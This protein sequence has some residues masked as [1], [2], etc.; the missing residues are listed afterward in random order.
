MG[1]VVRQHSKLAKFAF[2][3]KYFVSA[4]LKLGSEFINYQCKETQDP[5]WVRTDIGE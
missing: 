2:E 5:H 1:K 3:P 4:C